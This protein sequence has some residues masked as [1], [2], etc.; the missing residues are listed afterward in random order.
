MRKLAT[1]FF[2]SVLHFEENQT[3]C[4]VIENP[5]ILRAFLKDIHFQIQGE[6][7]S[8]IFSIDDRP[9]S[10]KGEVELI[11]DF[12][13]LDTNTKDILSSLI[14]QL[15]E[16]FLGGEEYVATQD[17][18]MRLQ[19]LVDRYSL[20]FPLPVDTTKLTMVNLLKSMGLK[21]VDED[22]SLPE[23]LLCY[24]KSVRHFLNDRLFVFI[25]LHA[26]LSEKEMENL[27]TDIQSE[28]F[29][30]LLV[31]SSEPQLFFKEKCLII[32][33]DCCEISDSIDPII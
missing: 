21:F 13:S 31:E 23:K 19:S 6:P 26:Y 29:D 10:M 25:N 4:L 20:D 24:M 30:V 18:L 5:E 16:R 2:P 32:D 28:K 15:Q 12:I 7:G 22:L 14:K 1:P 8:T 17:L 9:L 11:S 33:K 27:L 3:L